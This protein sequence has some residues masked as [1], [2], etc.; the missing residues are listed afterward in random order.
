LNNN[1][2]IAGAAGFASIGA[3]FSY[4]FIDS[5]IDN[6]CSFSILGSGQLNSSG[7]AILA[8]VAIGSCLFT[9][10]YVLIVGKDSSKFDKLVALALAATAIFWLANLILNGNVCSPLAWREHVTFLIVPSLFAILAVV[11]RKWLNKNDE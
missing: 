2:Q 3:F 11:G 9:F 8:S 10:C 6:S 5:L 1:D 7:T 4:L